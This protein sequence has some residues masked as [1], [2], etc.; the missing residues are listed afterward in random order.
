MSIKELLS[1]AVEQ[2]NEEEAVRVME[3]IVA[4]KGEEPLEHGDQ[5]A[6]AEAAR[7]GYDSWEQ[8]RQDLGL[9]VSD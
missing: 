4:L 6:L 3:F 8:V 5:E 1:R 9:D 2:L 7:E